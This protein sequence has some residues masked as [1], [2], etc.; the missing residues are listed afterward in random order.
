MG[1]LDYVLKCLTDSS[2]DS[3]PLIDDIDPFDN[4]TYY[5]KEVDYNEIPNFKFDERS[6]VPLKNLL[7]DITDEETQITFH[8]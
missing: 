7:N 6:I 3:T 1:L 5:Q 2:T 4:S 8:I